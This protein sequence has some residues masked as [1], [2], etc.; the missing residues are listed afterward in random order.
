MLKIFRNLLL[1]TAIS[2]CGIIPDEETE[3]EISESGVSVAS[4]LE[5][6]VAQILM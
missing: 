2:G 1:I 4:K 6:N 3:R 5:S